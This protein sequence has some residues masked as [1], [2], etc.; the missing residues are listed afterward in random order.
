MYKSKYILQENLLN[1]I[2]HLPYEIKEIIF[3]HYINKINKAFKKKMICFFNKHPE[4][5]KMYS[6]E[7]KEATTDQNHCIT[8]RIFL[9]CV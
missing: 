6:S 4:Y 3:I 1:K 5:R 7:L 9:Q 2:N 8:Y